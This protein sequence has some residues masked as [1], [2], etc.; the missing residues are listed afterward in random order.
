MF[1]VRRKEDYRVKWGNRIIEHTEEHAKK[2]LDHDF[3]AILNFLASK[4][5]EFPIPTLLDGW[6]ATFVYRKLNEPGHGLGRPA[7]E[8]SLFL[9][10]RLSRTRPVWVEKKGLFAPN[11]V[12]IA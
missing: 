8:L 1:V 7:E 6:D 3:L 12:E 11:W 10:M 5:L 4:G 9:Y 2:F